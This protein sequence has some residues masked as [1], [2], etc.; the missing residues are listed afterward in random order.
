MRLDGRRGSAEWHI[1]ADNNRGPE[2]PCMAAI[3][4]A[5]KLARGEITVTGAHPCMGFLDLADF[6]PEFA[7]WGMTTVI[8]EHP[9]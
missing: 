3:L 9:A 2:I 6:E 7:R 1:T 8:E 5:R 4:T